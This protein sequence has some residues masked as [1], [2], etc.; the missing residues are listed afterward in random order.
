[1]AN[2][3]FTERLEQI[4]IGILLGT[5]RLEIPGQDD[6]QADR[7]RQ[8]IITFLI[9]DGV[10]APN[11]SAIR[12]YA[13]DGGRPLGVEYRQDDAWIELEQQERDGLGTQLT[14]EN[15]KVY[16]YDATHQFRCVVNATTR[17]T[18]VTGP[19]PQPEV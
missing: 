18:P 17:L 5:A 8:K 4:Q 2:S 13:K 9:G 6:Y 19:S 10:T 16:L 11:G 14:A 3:A 15:G 1:V 12:A 7:K